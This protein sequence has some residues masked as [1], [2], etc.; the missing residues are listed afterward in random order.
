MKKL[1][2]LSV[3]ILTVLSLNAQIS[4]VQKRALKKA[5]KIQIY[6]ISGDTHEGY[7][8]YADSSGVI[9]SKNNLAGD[10]L[11][12]LS[13]ENLYKIS[14][15][16]GNTFWKPAA[17]GCLSAT[18]IFTAFTVGGLLISGDDVMVGPGFIAAVGAIVFGV[19]TGTVSGLLFRNK[20]SSEI[21]YITGAS[22]E[23][24]YL[25]SNMLKRKSFRKKVYSNEPKTIVSPE[26]NELLLES[27]VLPKKQKHPSNYTKFHISA[28]AP[29]TLVN[30]SWQIRQNYRKSGFEEFENLY[31]MPATN[32]EFSYSLQK[33]IRAF[34]S[35]TRPYEGTYLSSDRN[36]NF[37]KEHV[38][39]NIIPVNFSFGGQYIFSPVTRSFTKR[40]EFF[41]GGGITTIMG[42]YESNLWRISDDDNNINWD[43]KNNN[44]IVS[45]LQLQAGVNYYIIRYLSISTSL[46]SNLVGNSKISSHTATSFNGNFMSISKFNYN[47]S[48]LY[49][50]FGV[51]LHF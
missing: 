47:H 8:W 3:I 19:P 28:K 17:I 48:G 1:L 20:F 44:F 15:T 2:L 18:T 9:I 21:N 33:N 36:S 27:I 16:K 22:D 35:F 13:P 38:A 41:V 29:I 5:T 51:Q 45:G 49:I 46:H 34:A 50:N 42:R 4:K 11:Y 39:A 12:F 31:N 6:D 23:E 14:M 37:G 40:H 24:Y 25:Y 26:R 7:I 10:S 30:M 43:S 32:Y